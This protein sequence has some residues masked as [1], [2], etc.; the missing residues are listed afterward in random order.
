MCFN[1]KDMTESFINILIAEDNKVSRDMMAGLLATQGY[2]TVPASDGDEAIEVIGKQDIDL[3]LVDINMAPTGGFEFV[4]HLVVKGI[5]IPVV[6]VTG[7]DST[8]MLVEATGLGVRR[9]LQKPIDPKRLLDTV[10][11]LLKRKGLNPQP[12]VIEDHESVMSPEK[13]MGRA[14]ELAEK[15]VARGKGGPY[16]AIVANQEGRVIGEGT[17]GASSRVDPTAHAEVMAIRQAAEKLGRADL[18][19]CAL[20]VSSEPTKMGKALIV[21]VGIKE[22]YY[23]LSH[24]DTGGVSAHKE[25]AEPTYIQIERDAAMAMFKAAKS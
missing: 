17:N 5:D 10:N 24:E 13:L 9:V 3:A 11:T 4:K 14:I 2:K 19:D 6:V 1:N 25:T 15:N 20:Y 18:S 21:S 8:D 23:A 16:G 22:V 12:L 7:D